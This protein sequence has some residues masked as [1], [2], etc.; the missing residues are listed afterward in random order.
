MEL[1]GRPLPRLDQRDLTDVVPGRRRHL[2]VT[3]LAGKGME[4][5]RL[6][7]HAT[8]SHPSSGMGRAV[9]LAMRSMAK[10]EVT[11]LRLWRAVSW[12]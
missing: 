10:W 6:P 1:W 3:R 12:R 4:H 2:T 8:R 9:E 11:A 7:F 5:G